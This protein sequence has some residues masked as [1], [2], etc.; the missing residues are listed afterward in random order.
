MMRHYFMRCV[1]TDVFLYP[2]DLSL[3]TTNKIL[4]D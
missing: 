4:V 3:K 1:F 2:K